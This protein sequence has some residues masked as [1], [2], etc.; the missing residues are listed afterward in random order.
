M[1]L[2]FDAKS[3]IL[4]YVTTLTQGNVMCAQKHCSTRHTY[5]NV[6]LPKEFAASQLILKC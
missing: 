3:S 6:S 5:H 1:L 4:N 2:M